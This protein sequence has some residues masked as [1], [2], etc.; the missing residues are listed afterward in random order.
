MTGDDHPEP[1]TARFQEFFF[2]LHSVGS[3]SALAMPWPVGPRNSG[4]SSLEALALVRTTPSSAR[5]IID[6]GMR[7]S[8]RSEGGRQVRT[9]NG[10]RIVRRESGNVGLLRDPLHGFGLDGVGGTTPG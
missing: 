2:V 9:T 8:E 3:A 10:A 7:S 6:R 5:R 1:G 4:Q